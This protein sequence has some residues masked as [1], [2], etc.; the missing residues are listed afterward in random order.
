M[1][2][3]EV[4]KEAEIN[5]NYLSINMD[6]INNDKYQNLDMT[7]VMLYSLYNNRLS[8]SIYNSGD[9]SWT[10]REGRV[11]ILFTNEEAAKILRV[12]QRKITTCRQKLIDENLIEINKVGLKEHRIFLATPEHSEITKV[13]PYKNTVY[14]KTIVLHKQHAKKATSNK[15]N[16]HT[17]ASNHKNL[18]TNDTKETVTNSDGVFE[19]TGNLDDTLLE[20]LQQ[21][22]ANAINPKAFARI[23][24]IT[25]NNYSQTKWFVDTIFK[26]KK[27]AQNMFVNAGLPLAY[28]DAF[29]FEENKNYY[30]GLESAMIVTIEQVYRYGNVKNPKAFFY[31][32]LRGFFIEQAK[33]YLVEN[34]EI[35]EK[36]LKI[37]NL[38]QNKKQKPQKC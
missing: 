29:S 35:D 1:L 37:I 9:G 6:L 8:C 26:A 17:S 31:I 24:N 27:N 32:F 33:K 11:Y 25:N 3:N 16:N 30:D 38:V 22:F 2:K 10:D 19:N 4:T 13:M 5:T 12:S 23:K 20:G 18:D 7:T 28:L 34:Y 21:R 15:Q 36:T 14:Q